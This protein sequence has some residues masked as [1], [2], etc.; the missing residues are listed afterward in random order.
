MT[1][2]ID[3][4]RNTN[5]EILDL[6]I[7]EI[8]PSS[9]NAR[10]TFAEEDLQQLADSIRD[11]GLLEPVVVRWVESERVGDV[12]IGA[13]YELIA[14]ERRWRASKLAGQE[15]ILARV[16]TNVDDATALKL[17][18]VENLQRVN[19]NPL[20][21]AEGYRVL[22]DELGMT[23]RAI[24]DA[25][26]RSQP[27]VANAMRLLGLPDDVQELI[28][29][30]RLSRA[31]G[32]AI[33]RFRES[34]A[35]MSRLAS[36]AVANRTSAHS[37]EQDVPFA[38]DLRQEGLVASIHWNAPYR[39]TCLACPFDAYRRISDY[40]GVCLRL[41]HHAEL[42]AQVVAERQAVIDKQRESA[43]G[44]IDTGTLG[45]ED[46]EPLAHSQQPVGCSEDCPCRALAARKDGTTY[47]ICIDPK[48]FRQLK[49]AE[50]KAEKQAKRDTLRGRI[51]ALEAQV[52]GLEACGPR[53]IAIICAAALTTLHKP[54]S[55]KAAAE[56]FVPA[57]AGMKFARYELRDRQRGSLVTAAG[58]DGDALLRLT[59]EALLR[60]ELADRYEGYDSTTPLNDWYVDGLEQADME[61]CIVCGCELSGDEDEQGSRMCS[62]CLEAGQCQ[63]CNEP[64][65]LEAMQAG[66]RLCPGC[67]ALPGTSLAEV[68]AST[69]STCNAA[70]TAEDIEQGDQLCADCWAKSL[71]AD[72]HDE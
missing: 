7:D 1:A 70:L 58:G 56:R 27:A 28:R 62:E 66:E 47:P 64:L 15:T 71:E 67:C 23:Q 53:E 12:S 60:D 34:P 13:H 10:K 39:E 31:H 36:L 46:Y 41:E 33:L 37:L 63:V 14:G 51:E 44:V 19:L 25:V 26:N 32:V 18:L 54:T 42:E 59:V 49:A 17:G 50:Q 9:R 55:G 45:Y 3:S 43:E 16:L 40:S 22:A 6:P 2:T 8:R 35:V 29:E 30:G 11:H 69:C 24:A 21:E 65:T 4:A 52:A 68:L 61:Q 72:G 57:L 38:L 5:S 20:E 48:R